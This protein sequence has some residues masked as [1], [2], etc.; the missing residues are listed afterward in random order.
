MNVSRQKKTLYIIKT[1]DIL[2]IYKWFR[3]WILRPISQLSDALS[4]YEKEVFLCRTSTYSRMRKPRWI[5]RHFVENEK[6]LVQLDSLW[7]RLT[8]SICKLYVDSIVLIVRDMFM[9]RLLPHHP[10]PP[11]RGRQLHERRQAGGP[12]LSP[13]AVLP[14]SVWLKWQFLS[15]S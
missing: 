10:R 11:V 4:F 14:I 2:S 3:P 9:C 13:T 1:A 6:R 5:W 12:G 7:S 8:F 15:V